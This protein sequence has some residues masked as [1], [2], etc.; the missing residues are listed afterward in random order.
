MSDLAERLDLWYLFIAINISR[1]N[2]DYGFY[3]FQ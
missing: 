1:E 2:N 3:I